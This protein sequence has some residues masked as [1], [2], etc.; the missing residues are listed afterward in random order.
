MNDYPAGTTPAQH[1]QLADGYAEDARLAF[2]LAERLKVKAENHRR[3]AR[4]LYAL[5]DANPA[6][7]E[8]QR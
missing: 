2:A 1:D 7:Q 3:I 4:D 8:G 6:L 5:W